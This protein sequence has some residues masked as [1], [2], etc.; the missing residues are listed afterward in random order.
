MTAMFARIRWHLVGWN[1]L[2]VGLILG[3]LGTTL[4]VGTSR[5]LREQVD[6]DLASRGE[7]V[8]GNFRAASEGEGSSLGREGFQGGVFYLLV[9]ADGRILANPQNVDLTGWQLPAA[10]LTV[11]SYATSTLDGEPVRLYSVAPPPPGRRGAPA[12]PGGGPDGPGGPGGRGGP[13]G[14]GGP[15]LAASKPSL[16][17][18]Q[19]A[20]VVAGTS[21]EPA[22]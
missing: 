10:L 22:E 1:V 16:A 14:P 9:A 15:P 3:V 21:L 20:L 12:K 19:S 8:A 13:G 17:D 11:G 18:L 4:Y 2:V 5:N 7:Q 6:R